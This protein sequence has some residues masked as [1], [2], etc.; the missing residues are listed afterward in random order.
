MRVR[1]PQSRHL[2]RRSLDLSGVCLGV[3]GLHCA[4]SW[5][6]CCALRCYA[7]KFPY[8]I[9]KRPNLPFK[10]GDPRG[11][12]LEPLFLSA[13]ASVSIFKP[14]IIKNPAPAC[15]H[16]PVEVFAVAKDDGVDRHEEQADVADDP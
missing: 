16:K 3:V 4:T 8:L 6:P 12:F 2:L 13:L 1:G 5:S 9:L 11:K 15:D 7:L 14:P 10:I